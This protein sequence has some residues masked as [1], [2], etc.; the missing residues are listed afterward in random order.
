MRFSKLYKYL[1]KRVIY[2]VCSAI[3]N[4]LHTRLR[5]LCGMWV[6]KPVVILRQS[7]HLPLLLKLII[8]KGTCQI[9]LQIVF[10]ITHL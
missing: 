8:S 5:M 7:G 2:F 9:I 1:N 10:F 4:K 6:A 3:R